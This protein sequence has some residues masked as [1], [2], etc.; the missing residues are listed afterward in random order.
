MLLSS[1][2]KNVLISRGHKGD[3]VLVSRGLVDGTLLSL[4]SMA[5]HL[6]SQLC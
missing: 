6:N 2:H 4:H 5:F 1:G 3:H